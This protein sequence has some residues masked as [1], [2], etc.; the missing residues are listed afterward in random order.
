MDQTAL[1]GFGGYDYDEYYDEDYDYDDDDEN[2][3]DEEPTEEDEADES[4][5]TDRK[6]HHSV[7]DWLSSW[8]HWNILFSAEKHEL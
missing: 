5:S 7:L 2:D 1:Q 4:V 6:V 8:S 3:E